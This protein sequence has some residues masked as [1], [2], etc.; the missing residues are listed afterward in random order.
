MRVGG[1][2]TLSFFFVHASHILSVSLTHNARSERYESEWSRITV[3]TSPRC[4][5][6]F[7]CT[8][9]TLRVH[10]QSDSGA[11]LHA[12]LFNG[13]Q[14]PKSPQLGT[15]RNKREGQFGGR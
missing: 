11:S 3:A 1:V 15:Y 9:R 7:R 13:S 4:F 14:G 2:S 5:N 6:V 10:G 8:L 12:G